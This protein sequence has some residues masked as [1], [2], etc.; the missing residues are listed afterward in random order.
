VKTNRVAVGEY[1][2]GII[3]TF[4]GPGQTDGS[5]TGR[6]PLLVG[7]PTEA[8]EDL[9]FLPVGGYAV[10][11]V[12]TFVTEDL[13]GPAGDGPQLV[14]G[15]GATCT[16][17]DLN[18]CA[19]SVGGCDKALGGVAGGVDKRLGDGRSGQDGCSEGEECEC[20][21]LHDDE[22]LTKR[23]GVNGSQFVSLLDSRVFIPF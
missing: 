5:R 18:G 11:V 9:Q 23:I 12:E 17:R 4:G 7:V 1:T 8:S 13:Q 14:R 6:S 22:E 10:R 16:V 19:V 2:I 20:G 21:E 3:H 15:I